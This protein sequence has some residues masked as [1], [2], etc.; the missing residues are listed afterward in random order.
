[1]GNKTTVILGLALAG[2]SA[3]AYREHK[4]FS[5]ACLAGAKVGQRFLEPCKELL[6]GNALEMVSAFLSHDPKGNPNDPVWT[7][8]GSTKDRLKGSAGST[9]FADAVEGVIGAKGSA[10]E[11]YTDVPE[12]VM[13]LEPDVALPL[14]DSGKPEDDH[15][16]R[17]DTEGGKISAMAALTAR[18]VKAETSLPACAVVGSKPARP[19]D[20][21]QIAAGFCGV[22][23]SLCQ[24]LTD[25]G[26][27]ACLALKA[28]AN[29]KKY[30]KD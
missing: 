3:V 22:H 27:Q 19:S 17:D 14:P 8:D 1:M 9:Y 16:S 28:G 4:N 20:M 15:P 24:K 7:A 11:N 23:P 25:H 29:T 10:P 6:S 12:N 5:D 18:A 26:G 21:N 30:A 13:P 2:V